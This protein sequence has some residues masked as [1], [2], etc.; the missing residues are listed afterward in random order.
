MEKAYDGVEDFLKN[1]SCPS[2]F[3]QQQQYFQ[4]IMTSTSLAI[5]CDSYVQQ[6]PISSH[7]NTG[8]ANTPYVQSEQSMKSHS[9]H[10]TSTV[11][12]SQISTQLKDMFIRQESQSVL[13]SLGGSALQEHNNNFGRRMSCQM[14]GERTYMPYQP[15]DHYHHPYHHNGSHSAPVDLFSNTS[16]SYSTT[17]PPAYIKT[18]PF[19]YNG[20]DN[21]AAFSSG[22]SSP[23][24]GLDSQEYQHNGNVFCPLNPPNQNSHQLVP[25]HCKTPPHERPYP[26]PVDTCERRFSRSDELTRHIRIHTG[27]KPFQ[28]KICMRAFSRSDHLT[29]HV[30]T[31]TGEKP[32]SCDVCGRKFARSDEKKRHSKVHIKQRVKKERLAAASHSLPPSVSTINGN[33]STWAHNSMNIPMQMGIS[34]HPY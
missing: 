29:T 26:C 5:D 15:T 32:F 20:L 1:T 19:D 14:A 7:A 28:C 10:L 31:H 13:Q 21:A 27:Q 16:P 22:P 9:P 11:D 6:A 33:C 24:S 8:V 18:E 34:S 12:S 17:V 2:E 25:H 30:R 23:E 4:D 3:E